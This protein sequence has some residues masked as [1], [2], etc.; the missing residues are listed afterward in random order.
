MNTL[1][2]TI[3]PNAREE[4]SKKIY[5]QYEKETLAK[6][7]AALDLATRACLYMRQSYERNPDQFKD[8]FMG[9]KGY[10]MGFFKGIFDSFKSSDLQLGQGHDRTTLL[11]FSTYKKF[12]GLYGQITEGAKY[13]LESVPA[14][15]KLLLEVKDI[16]YPMLLKEHTG[17]K[18]LDRMIQQWKSSTDE[19]T[20]QMLIRNVD[21]ISKGMIAAGFELEVEAIRE[22]SNFDS[23][24]RWR[25]LDKYQT[26]L[27]NP[28]LIPKPWQQVLGVQTLMES[29]HIPEINKKP[30]GLQKCNPNI[31]ENVDMW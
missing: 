4:L 9:I 14:M 6:K 10:Y 15:D 18:T 11:I 19:T 2:L 1:K 23:S 3:G 27:L 17:L 24:A 20:T 30:R 29:P 26:L 21:S 12:E 25:W 8:Q 13:E 31:D 22:L 5:I 16:T 28:N 7:C